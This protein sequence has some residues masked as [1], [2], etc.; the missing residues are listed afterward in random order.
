MNKNRV[1]SNFDRFMV[2]KINSGALE[3]TFETK[4]SDYPMSLTIRVQI[5]YICSFIGPKKQPYRTTD[6]QKKSTIHKR[7]LNSSTT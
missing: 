1:L 4:F 5:E 3:H 6:Q 2:L 7:K